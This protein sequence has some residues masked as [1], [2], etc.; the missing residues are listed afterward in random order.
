M[1]NDKKSFLELLRFNAFALFHDF[2]SLKK[3]KTF[4]FQDTLNS[5]LKRI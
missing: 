5:V 1:N 2:I 4:F 3:I